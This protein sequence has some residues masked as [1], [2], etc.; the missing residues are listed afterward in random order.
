[1]EKESL[2]H[3]NE[4]FKILDEYKIDIIFQILKKSSDRS[5]YLKS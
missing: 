4:I 5:R 1:M 3:I 2:D